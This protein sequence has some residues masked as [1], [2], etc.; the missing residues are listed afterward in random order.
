MKNLP[1]KIYLN[2]GLTEDCAN[3]DFNE[4]CEVTWSVDKVDDSDIE[5]EKRACCLGSTAV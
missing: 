5:Y 3:V 4:L 1:D 2:L